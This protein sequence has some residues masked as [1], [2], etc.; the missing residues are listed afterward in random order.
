MD[1]AND[2]SWTVSAQHISSGSELRTSNPMEPKPF[3][4][5]WTYTSPELDSSDSSAKAH[6]FQNEL[7]E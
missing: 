7:H 1:K 2:F 6:G 4:D 5:E 3:V